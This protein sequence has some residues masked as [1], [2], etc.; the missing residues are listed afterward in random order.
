MKRIEKAATRVLFRLANRRH[1]VWRLAAM[2][3]LV[4]IVGVA[5]GVVGVIAAQ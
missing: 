4:F 2:V 5:A 1:T 3:A